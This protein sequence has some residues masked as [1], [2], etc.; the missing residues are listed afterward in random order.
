MRAGL[1]ARC[2]RG[3]FEATFCE[4]AAVADGA[5][6]WSYVST[7][8]MYDPL[9]LVAAVPALADKFRFDECIVHGTRHRVAGSSSERPGVAA[10]LQEWLEEAFVEGCTLGL[11]SED[12]RVVLEMRRL[13]NEVASLRARIAVT[14]TK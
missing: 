12:Q 14:G 1:P 8:N 2:D 7:F 10:S 5:D 3:W 9:A 13:R 6:V 4:G 11:P